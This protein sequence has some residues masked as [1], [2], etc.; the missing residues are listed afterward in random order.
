MG[1][2]KVPARDDF[3]GTLQTVILLNKV[4]DL[5]K[6]RHGFAKFQPE[7]MHLSEISENWFQNLIASTPF[8]K[9][10]IIGEKRVRGIIL[11]E[12]QN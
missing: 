5:L 9:V 3:L 10:Q 2:F 7:L 11:N 4:S 8:L 12:N 6:A 1:F